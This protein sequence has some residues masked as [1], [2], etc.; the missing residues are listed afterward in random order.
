MTVG[1]EVDSN[2][3]IL[4]F[5]KTSLGGLVLYCFQSFESSM[6]NENTMIQKTLSFSGVTAK[7]KSLLSPLNFAYAPKP[8]GDKTVALED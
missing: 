4:V 3:H 1:D 8:A 2:D 5:I 7:L 6:Y